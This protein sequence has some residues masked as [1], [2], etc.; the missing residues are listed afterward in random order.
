V[1]AVCVN[2]NPIKKELARGRI[3]EE[4]LRIIEILHTTLTLPLSDFYGSTIQ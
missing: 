2:N 1:C 3:F 4:S